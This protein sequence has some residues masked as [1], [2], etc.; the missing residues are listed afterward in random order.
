MNDKSIDY[1]R[2]KRRFAFFLYFTLRAVLTITYVKTRL[3]YT[4]KTSSYQGRIT[5]KNKISE[6]FKSS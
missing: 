6:K 5:A 1:H 4:E 3:L 2:L